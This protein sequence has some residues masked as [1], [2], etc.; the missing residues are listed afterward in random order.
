MAA[1]K[2]RT[3]KP[4]TKK[5]P[6]KKR[7][8]G[9]PR[10]KL[11]SEPIDLA[12]GYPVW[13]RQEKEPAKAFAAF[14]MFKGMDPGDR[15]VSA[16]YRKK[17][18]RRT[19]Q[20]SGNWYLWARL[21]RWEERASVWDREV[22]RVQRDDELREEAERRTTARRSRIGFYGESLKLARVKLRT[23]FDG[24]GNVRKNE[25]GVPLAAALTPTEAS[26]MGRVGAEGLRAEYDEEPTQRHLLEG[27]G[28]GPIQAQVDPGAAL[29]QLLE[30]LA[31]SDG[32]GAPDSGVPDNGAAAGRPPKRKRTAKPTPK[33]K[34]KA[35]PR[36]KPTA[37]KK[38]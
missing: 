5:R 1:K 23:Y 38:K 16:A 30:K 31:N 11:P 24:H 33:A 14:E 27:P 34:L 17:T 29:V 26:R 15:S 4:A 22:A 21:F 25:K 9:A 10:P 37:K 35:K 6:T 19:T 12:Q 20:A 2:T 28:G 8:T 36:H 3:R 13:E 7:S 32:D 18:H